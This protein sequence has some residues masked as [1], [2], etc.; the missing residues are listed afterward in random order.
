MQ[1]EVYEDGYEKYS[2]DLKHSSRC[3]V[4]I[5]N[6]HAWQSITVEETAGIPLTEKVSNNRVL[7]HSSCP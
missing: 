6:S 1:Q 3:F 7:I 4:H 5:I 2:W